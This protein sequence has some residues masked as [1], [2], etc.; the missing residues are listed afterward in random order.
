MSNPYLYALAERVHGHLGWLG[1]AVLLH[2]VISL[3]VRKG[4]SRGTRLSAILA[5]ILMVLPYG[6]GWWIYPTYRERVKPALLQESIPWVLAFEA[7]EHLAF[8]AVALT[9]GGTGALLLDGRAAQTRSAAWS[10]LTLGWLCGVA[11]GVLG[12]LIAARA[13][14]AW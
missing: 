4:I 10:L 7:K 5:A 2:P 1:L 12:V 14:P 8:M 3:R 13:H 9:I 6:L 11:T